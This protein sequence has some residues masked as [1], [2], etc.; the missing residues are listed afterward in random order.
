MLEI[1]TNI[2]EDM[3]KQ[4]NRI[5][6]SLDRLDDDLIWTRLK[7]STNSIGNLC[8]HLA[9]NEYQNLVS[10]IGGKPF[11]RERSRREFEP[12]G[13]ITRDE[14]KQLLLGTRAESA[15]ILSNLAEED[16]DREVTIRYSLE[17]WNRMHRVNASEDETYD[18]RSVRLLLIQVATHYGYHAGQI[19]LISKLLKDTD[20]HITGQ[21]H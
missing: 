15:R 2:L 18:V 4:L 11:I 6:K 14:L 5:L 8:L 12:E 19:V 3:D 10:A 7:A 9:G 1:V 16:L 21:Y 13:G 17:D 20:E